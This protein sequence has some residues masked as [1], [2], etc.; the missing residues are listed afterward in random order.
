MRASRAFKGEGEEKQKKRGKESHPLSPDFPSFFFLKGDFPLS[1]QEGGEKKKKKGGEG[2]RPAH[3]GVLT[4][5][6]KKKKIFK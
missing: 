3:L 5:K 2:P 4:K 1:F 6:K